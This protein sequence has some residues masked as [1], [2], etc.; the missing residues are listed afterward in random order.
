M[1]GVFLYA[2]LSWALR[3][4]REKVPKSFCHSVTGVS[5]GGVNKSIPSVN[6][7]NPCLLWVTWHV[8]V[9]CVVA[10]T[11]GN[12]RKKRGVCGYSESEESLFT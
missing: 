12:H 5:G 1:Q 7:G 10:G 11:R 4:S 2:Q 6:K 9:S 3:R 8:Y